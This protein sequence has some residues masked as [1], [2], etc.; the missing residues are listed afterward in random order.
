MIAKNHNVAALLPQKPAK[1]LLELEP[2]LA[3]PAKS[4]NAH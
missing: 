4:K 3:P 1:S 2:A